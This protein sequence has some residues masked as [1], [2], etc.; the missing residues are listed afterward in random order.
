MNPLCVFVVVLIA[1]TFVGCNVMLVFSHEAAHEQIFSYYGVDSEVRVD[2][3]GGARTVVQ[4]PVLD[5]D[6]DF[7]YG[8]HA[9]NEALGYQVLAMFNAFFL[10]M[11][12]MLV[13]FWDVVHGEAS[14]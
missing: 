3:F 1:I 12:F 14:G 6:R 11:L 13:L 4:G 5:E 9:I 7:V 2:L 8:L 10:C